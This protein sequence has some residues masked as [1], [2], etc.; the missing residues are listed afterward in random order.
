VKPHIPDPS[1]IDDETLLRLGIAAALE[2]PDGSVSAA[3]LRREA[4]HGRLQIWRIAG[5]DFTSRRAL[6]EM[7]ER[8]ARP[9]HQDSSC[10]AHAKG[11]G[12]SGSSSTK[13]AKSAQA[14]ALA[15]AQKL[16][17]RSRTI[18]S[19]TDNRPL[20]PVIPLKS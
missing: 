6:K 1:R 12:P 20:A 13:N 9:S 18:S 3:G 10:D 8:C 15:S 4:S 11:A 14:L 7:R 19:K 5:K 16:K 2:F 17:S